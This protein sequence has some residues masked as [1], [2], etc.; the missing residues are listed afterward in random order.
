MATRVRFSRVS[1]PLKSVSSLVPTGCDCRQ[2][3]ASSEFR[4]LE[5]GQEAQAFHLILHLWSKPPLAWPI[6][7]PYLNTTVVDLSSW[8]GS[9]LPYI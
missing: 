7:P 8:V 3:M 5:R 6:F 4:E 1:V 2:Y 9:N